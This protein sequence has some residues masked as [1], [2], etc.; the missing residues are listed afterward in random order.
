M[1]ND[2]D[3]S[4][5]VK[6][7]RRILAQPVA[8]GFTILNLETGQYYELEGTAAHI[9]QAIS[10]TASP[11]TIATRLARRF[12]VGQKMVLGDV[13]KLVDRLETAGL[14]VRQ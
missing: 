4:Q 9:W 12:S 11:A 3:A 13:L 6:P 5:T 8:S 1:T 2:M 14:A 10:E 7:A